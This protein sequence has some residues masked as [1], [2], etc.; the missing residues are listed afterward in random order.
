VNARDESSSSVRIR[1][2]DPGAIRR[3]VTELAAAVRTAHHEV[4]RIR[5]FG[6]WITGGWSLGSDVDLCIVVE[7]S[8]KPVR[9][10]AVEFL[11]LAFPV[12]LDIFVY[13]EAELERLR[14]EH[15]SFARAMD[16]GE[17]L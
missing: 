14:M 11:P 9:D 16:A 5:W 1:Y 4:K 2:A 7:R 17:E 13:T 3:D 15:P 8:A 6:S 10:R 12:G